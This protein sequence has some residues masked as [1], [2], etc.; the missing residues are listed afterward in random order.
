MLQV[1][2]E[3][4]NAHMPGPL[5]ARMRALMIEMYGEYFVSSCTWVARGETRDEV[6][7]IA[8]EHVR[9]EHAVR[10]WPP[11]FWI[12]MRESIHEA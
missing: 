12:H 4:V 1:S 3:V 8:T 6:L 11:E 10:S 7:A 9:A 5:A 2:C